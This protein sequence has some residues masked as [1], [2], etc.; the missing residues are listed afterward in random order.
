VPSADLP[1]RLIEENMWRA[2]RHG[3]DGEMLDLERAQAYPASETLER[4]LRWCEPACGELG[5]EVSLPE[6][7]GAQRQRGMIDA[8]LGMQEIYAAVV[9]ETKRTYAGQLGTA[10]VTR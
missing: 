5:I 2:I 6:R 8:G 9:A 10:E 4:L 3:L 7:N 1:G